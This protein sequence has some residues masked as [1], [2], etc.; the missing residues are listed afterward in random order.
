MNIIKH[1]DHVKLGEQVITL[2]ITLTAVIVGITTYAYTAFQLYW[3]DNG[4]VITERAKSAVEVIKLTATEFYLAG[5]D[6]RLSVANY[7]V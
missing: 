1:F 7:T 3:L 6:L 4:E 2:V 5:R